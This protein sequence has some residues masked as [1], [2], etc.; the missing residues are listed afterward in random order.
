MQPG[1]DAF[2]LRKHIPPRRTYRNRLQ[3]EN[4]CF[5]RNALAA[6]ALSIGCDQASNQG[7]LGLP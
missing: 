3:S 7:E 4:Q 2:P 5:C 6:I 1:I